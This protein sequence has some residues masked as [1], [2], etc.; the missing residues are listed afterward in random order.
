MPIRPENRA[1]YPADWKAIVAQVR[2]RS[3]DRCECRGECGRDSAH[4][5]PEDGRCLC[6]QGGIPFRGTRANVVLTTAHR[7]H[8]PEHCDLGNLFHACQGCHLAYD[9]EHH[10][11]TA[12]RTRREGK[13]V[14][15][16]LGEGNG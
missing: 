11:Q 4:L 12:Y 15:D 5:S 13:A 7:D 3:G 6:F 9:R 10:A 2:E 1:R 16:L 14:A 8:V